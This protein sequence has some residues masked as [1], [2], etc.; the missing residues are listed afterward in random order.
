MLQKLGERLRKLGNRLHAFTLGT[1]IALAA[2][3]LSQAGQSCV[4]AGQ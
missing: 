1:T 3:L 4:L 2:A